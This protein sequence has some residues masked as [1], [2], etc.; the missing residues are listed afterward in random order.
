M[1]MKPTSI[2]TLASTALICFAVIPTNAQ[3]SPGQSKTK[4]P[5]ESKTP[6]ATK[7]EKAT[8]PDGPAAKQI[9]DY[10]AALDQPDAAATKPFLSKACKDD[11]TTE[12]NAN[13]KS[14]WNLS[15][16]DSQIRSETID[17]KTGVAT[18]KAQ[19]VFKGG[20]TFM[21]RDVTFTLKQEDGEWKI[22]SMTPPPKAQ[23]PG[24]TPL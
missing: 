10:I 17:K 19:I 3:T 1:K 7:D 2:A 4:K 20:S 11:F 23:A 6:S 22:V 24:F 14:G 9:R 21:G 18:V 15:L 16:A 12:K 5:A 8:H 13:S